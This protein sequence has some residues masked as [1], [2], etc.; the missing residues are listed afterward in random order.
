MNYAAILTFFQEKFLGNLSVDGEEAGNRQ[1]CFGA[2]RSRAKDCSGI[3]FQ[4][5]ITW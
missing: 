1:V 2:A 4:A 5:W 3:F